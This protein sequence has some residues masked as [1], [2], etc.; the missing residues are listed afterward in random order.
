M[1]TWITPRRLG[2]TAAL[3]AVFVSGWYVGQPLPGV[4]CRSLEPAIAVEPPDRFREPGDVSADLIRTYRSVGKLVTTQ[5]VDTASVL[6]CD[7][8]TPRPRLVAWVTG[9]WR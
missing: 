9:D 5:V 8:V 4:G 6:P 1:P 2:A 3:Y 7:P